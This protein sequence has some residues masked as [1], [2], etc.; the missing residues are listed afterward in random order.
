MQIDASASLTSMQDLQKNVEYIHQASEYNSTQQ[1]S[2]PPTHASSQALTSVLGGKQSNTTPPSE[3]PQELPA[4]DDERIRTRTEKA[5]ILVTLCACTFLSAMEVTVTTTALPTIS[6]SFTSDAGYSWVGSAYLLANAA[7]SSTWGKLSDIW[8]RKPIV[9]LAVSLFAIGSLMAGL[10]INLAMLIAARALQGIGGGGMMVMVNICI[11][12]LFSLRDRAK[13]LGLT[14]VVWVVA[15][16]VGPIIGGVLTERI[17]WRWCFFITLPVSCAAIPALYCFLDLHNPRTPINV[18]LKAVDWTGSFLVISGTV[19]LLLGLEFGGLD[20]A[21]TS[22]QVLI[23][24]VFGFATLVGFILYEWKISS[25]PIMPLRLFKHYNNVAALI[26]CS[27]QSSTFVAGIYFLPLYFQAVLG[28]NPLRSGFYILPFVLTL[29]V[30]SALTGIYVKKTGRNIS[31]IIFGLFFM[32]I[33]FSLFM[34]F[35]LTNHWEKTIIYQIIA[36][37][38]VGPNFQ[39]PLIALQSMTPKKDIAAATAN[40]NFIRH[41]STSSSL[42]LGSLI[43]QGELRKRCLAIV[44]T[45]GATAAEAL[46]KSSVGTS[47]VTIQ[48]LSSEQQLL[49]RKA[50]LASL[51]ITWSGYVAYSSLSLLTSLGFSPNRLKQ[52]PVADSEAV[53]EKEKELNLPRS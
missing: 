22:I 29:S 10:S 43:F 36:G 5:L 40:Y 27:S 15:C 34:N 6:K 12:D 28:V 35:D 49:A 2:T 52:R 23:L 25:N 24:L 7:F 19:M 51:R 45:L 14:G 33:G 39:S 31:T 20:Y 21:W 1:S 17:S 37:V 47:I 46:S 32:I 26:V 4:N 48:N 9:I 41:L 50:V 42:I 30:T 18:G 11:S 44:S 3:L 8:G 53:D 13:Y 38:G 16:S